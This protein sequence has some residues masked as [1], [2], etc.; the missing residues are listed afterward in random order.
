MRVAR[1]CAEAEM[2]MTVIQALTGKSQH[3][4]C[5]VL[6]SWPGSLEDIERHVRATGKLPRICEGD[7]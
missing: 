2:H 1:S 3:E 4:I 7:E 5:K 6:F